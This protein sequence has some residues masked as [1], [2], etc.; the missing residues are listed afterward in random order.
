MMD[1]MFP[2]PMVIW[3][4]GQHAGNYAPKVIR[5]PLFEERAV[6]A[7]VMDNKKPH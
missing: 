1:G 4:E 7:V 2:T 6:S 3:D 5:S